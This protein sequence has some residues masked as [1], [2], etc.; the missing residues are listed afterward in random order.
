MVQASIHGRLGRNP[1]PLPRPASSWQRPASPWTRD[2]IRDINP[3]ESIMCFSSQADALLRHQGNR[4][5]VLGKL[6]RSRCATTNRAGAI[7]PGET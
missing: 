7:I 1:K 3:L 6:P 5:G 2:S 4:I